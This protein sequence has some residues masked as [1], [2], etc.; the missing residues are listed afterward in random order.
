MRFRL[1]FQKTQAMRFT[2][3]LDLQHTWMRALRRAG[4][5]LE[6]SQGFHPLPKVQLASALP[7]GCTGAAEIMDIWTEKDWIPAEM[8]LCLQPVLPPGIRLVNTEVVD[9]TAPKVQ[10]A[11][12]SQ[13]YRVELHQNTLTSDLQQR[14]DT[15][16]A[17]TESIAE[18][19]GKSINIRPL[20]HEIQ[21]Q[22]SESGMVLMMHMS[23][24]ESATGRPD[25]VLSALG[26]N[27]AECLVERTRLIF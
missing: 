3:H 25:E 5:A 20:I 13:E 12:R 27:P 23:A 7:L 2:G 19:R 8:D 11:L 22:R 21:L 24:Q 17:T 18:R 26:V 4:I 14:I 10:V 1:T 15:L 9:L 6:H 16:M